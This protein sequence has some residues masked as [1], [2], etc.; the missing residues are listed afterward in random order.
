[1]ENNEGKAAA[2]LDRDSEIAS[3]QSLSQEGYTAFEKRRYSQ[4]E[5]KFQDA[6]K[7]A[8]N[9]TAGKTVPSYVGAKNAPGNTT[10]TADVE[11]DRADFERLTKTLNNLA[12][13][14]QLQGKYEMAEAMYDRC[15][16]L[17]LDLYGDDHLEVAINLHNLASLQCAKLRWEKAEILY[18]R[19]LEIR[20]KHLG[21]NHVELLPILKNYATML[22]KVRREEEALAL[23]ERKKQIEE[24][25]A[26]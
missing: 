1:M 19:A 12:A 13:L 15:L 17:R 22:R 14:Y 26:K 21:K 2:T 9:L 4:A 24:A 8:E 6:L 3:W 10:E 23:E 25:K 20:E 18:K 11:V 16:D 5:T 7:F